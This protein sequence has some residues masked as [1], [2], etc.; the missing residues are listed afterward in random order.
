M[1]RVY[2]NTCIRYFISIYTYYITYVMCGVYIFFKKP[3]RCTADA[4]AHDDAL[5]DPGGR[6][7]DVWANCFET[8][9]VHLGTPFA[10]TEVCRDHRA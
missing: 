7:T 1:E 6:P 8:M 2:R 9:H 10:A 4:F 3:S 5:T